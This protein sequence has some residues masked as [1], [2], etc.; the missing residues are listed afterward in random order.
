MTTWHALAALGIVKSS[1]ILRATPGLSKSL[2]THY[3]RSVKP[4]WRAEHCTH[5]PT[6]SSGNDQPSS[7]EEVGS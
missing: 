2:H 6:K 1:Y 3:Q 5:G 4:A 7:I